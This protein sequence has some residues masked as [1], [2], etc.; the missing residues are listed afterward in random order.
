[1]QTN[2]FNGESQSGF[3]VDG[4]ESAI[5]FIHFIVTSIYFYSRVLVKWE[6]EIIPSLNKL[7][8]L[9]VCFSVIFSKITPY[10][11][12]NIFGILTLKHTNAVDEEGIRPPVSSLFG[13]EGSDKYDWTEKWLHHLRQSLFK[14]RKN[15]TN[16]DK[17]PLFNEKRLTPSV[18][19]DL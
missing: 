10:F 13:F 8:S 5:G 6:G 1:M 7:F 4:D 2:R 11:Y 17:H 18:M 16:Y 3:L 15:Y 9:F 12:T 14:R 19:I